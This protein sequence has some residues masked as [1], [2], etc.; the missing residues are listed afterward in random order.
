MVNISVHLNYSKAKFSLSEEKTNT[1]SNIPSYEQYRHLGIENGNGYFDVF[2][3]TEQAKELAD[4]IY[5][6]LQAEE[7]EAVD[8]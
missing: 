2:L 4:T 1:I 5:E 6:Q 7:K 3:T 8:V